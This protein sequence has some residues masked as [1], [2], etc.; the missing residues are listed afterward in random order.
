MK[1][2]IS[3]KL[4]SHFLELSPDLICIAG[5]DGFLKYIN[6]TWEKLLGYTE[7]ELLSKPF[8][9]FIHPHDH[10]KNDEEMFNLSK[11]NIIQDFENRYVCKNGEIKYIHWTFRPILEENVIYCIG[12]DITKKRITEDK[13]RRIFEN[14]PNAIAINNIETRKIIECNTSFET[15]FG[16]TRDEIL[17]KTTEKFW[18]IDEDRE[19]LLSVLLNEGKLEVKELSLLHKSGKTILADVN[20]TL[21]EIEG[22]Y[23]SVSDIVDISAKKEMETKLQE[24]DKNYKNLYKSALVALFQH[25]LNIGKVIH[26]NYA[27]AK[28]FGYTTIDEFKEKFESVNHY[29]NI[30]DRDHI[31]S[32]I[33]S[34]GRI[35][36]VLMHTK[37]VDGTLIWNEA[38]FKLS[39]SGILDC[40]SVDV[41]KRIEQE[42][43]LKQIKNIAVEHK[44]KF[45]ILSN[46][47]F[48]GILIHDKGVPISMNESFV[49]LFGYTQ[50]EI[51]S[52]D[53]VKMLVRKE[54]QQIVYNNIQNERTLPYEIIMLRKDGTEFP[55][56]IEGKTYFDK[57]NQKL[58]V[59]AFRDIT[60]RKL[61]AEEVKREKAFSESVMNAATDVIYIFNP[62]TGEP[63]YWNQANLDILGYTNEEMK[64]RLAGS[65]SFHKDE[66]LDR[67]EKCTNDC[68]EYGRSSIQVEARAKDNSY[69]PF[70]FNLSRIDRGQKEKYI[71]V[72]GRDVTKSK[73]AEN[74]LIKAKEKAEESDRL[75]SAFLANMSHEI[76]TPMNGIL[77]FTDLLKTPGLTGEKQQKYIKIIENSGARMLSTIH[78]IIDIS[79]IE[80]GQADV[81][82]SSIDLNQ[83]A[84]DFLEFFL[85]EANRKGIQLSIPNKLPNEYCVVKSDLEKLNSIVTNLIKN[86]IKYTHSGKIEFA[87]SI[88]KDTK[89]TKLEFHIKDTG[90]GIPKKRQTAIFERF[91]QADIED[92]K[93]YEGSGLGLAITK[94]YVEMLGGKI[95]VESEVNSGSKFSFSIPYKK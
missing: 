66:D 26:A 74:E 43:E 12:K 20:V 17:G 33:N 5:F 21:I 95:W 76:R 15:T 25:D 81:S 78:D 82:L 64:S 38:S 61:A 91:I 69:I 58:R 22:E 29:A 89:K 65:A 1:N 28:L 56:E 93:V 57:D 34:K 31:L 6:P 4:Q 45:E 16:Y 46:A 50:D 53:L 55:V 62:E 80:S 67:L 71:C 72:I 7:K 19:R 27:A 75:K 13:F 23:Y 48:E 88:K 10:P 44:T 84:D 18:K 40:A 47:T 49:K 52:A 36:N 35:D 68:L 73:E 63:I 70:D 51:D 79:T 24:K 41:T 30:E 60:E 54:H 3:P 14:S 39:K 37:K 42:N 8:L 32:E 2:N 83:H 9:D 87:Y 77:G 94:A 59:T 11:G 85:P 92:E 90:I 86:A